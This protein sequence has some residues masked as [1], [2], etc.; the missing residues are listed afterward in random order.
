M[1]MIIIRTSRP[2]ADNNNCDCNNC[3]CNNCDCNNNC[4]LIFVVITKL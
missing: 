2:A 4:D 1:I 3:V